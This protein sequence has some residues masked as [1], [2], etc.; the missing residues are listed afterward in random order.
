[1]KKL[2]GVQLNRDDKYAIKTTIILV[3]FIL[4]TVAFFAA[5]PT[6]VSKWLM[7]VIAGIQIGR[8]IF[9]LAKWVMEKD[10]D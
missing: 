9:Q 6:V 2:M 1:M 5:V 10:Y 3:A 8:W 4:V 7:V